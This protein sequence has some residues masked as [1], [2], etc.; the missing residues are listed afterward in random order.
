MASTS[1]GVA[2]TETHREV[3]ARLGAEVVG[4]ALELWRLLPVDDMETRVESWTAAMVP[5]VR[6]GRERSQAEALRYLQR[7]AEA[8]IGQVMAASVPTV[9]SRPQSQM[10]ASVEVA[11]PVRFRSLVGRG[12]EPQR[13]W[14]TA[15][16]SQAS[17]AMRLVLEAGREEV[18]NQGMRD[19]RTIGFARVTGPD[20]CPFCAMLASRGPVYKSA[21]TAAGGRWSS[22]N[23]SFKVHDACQCQIEPS[24]N[25]SGAWTEQAREYRQMWDESVGEARE[26]GLIG[27]GT[28]SRDALNAFRR[29]MSGGQVVSDRVRVPA[30]PQSTVGRSTG[31]VEPGL[32]QLRRLPDADVPGKVTSQRDWAQSQG[33]DVQVDGRRITGLS[34]SE[35]IVWR[36]D[37]F[38]RWIVDE[39]S[40]S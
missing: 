5:L 37:E 29:R 32:S 16:V 31:T 22:A 6:E 7:L 23:E 34:G 30:R 11:G 28:S 20:P 9:L 1:A 33:W 15:A 13:A 19:R 12:V 36:L 4:R 24:Y 14:R 8:E 2:A 21:D 18:F 10:L 17:T 25:L 38:G 39:L 40:R 35:R 27:Q 3:Q 26:A